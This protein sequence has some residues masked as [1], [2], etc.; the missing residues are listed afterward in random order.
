M[1]VLSRPNF[2]LE[3][4]VEIADIATKIDQIIIDNMTHLI[5]PA[6]DR[7]VRHDDKDS[8]ERL[9]TDI[10]DSYFNLTS[11]TTDI[12]REGVIED[13]WFFSLAHL[14]ARLARKDVTTNDLFEGTAN[15]YYT[16]ARVNNRV[17]VLRPTQA[18]PAVPSG[19]IVIDVEA[20]QVISSIITALKSANILV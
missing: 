16:D 5:A 4:S 7:V 20:R 18:S 12:I 10:A 8:L 17:N 6:D 1:S 15:L 2:L 14:Q 9:V 13:K 11:D 3:I 19:G